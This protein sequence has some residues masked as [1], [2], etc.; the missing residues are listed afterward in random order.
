MALKKDSFRREYW[1]RLPFPFELRVYIFNVTNPD[2]IAK[3]GKPI[4]N[5]VGPFIYDILHEKIN[6]ED[7]EENDTVSYTVNNT[8]YF[9]IEKSNNLSDNMELTLVD[10]LTFGTANAIMKSSPALISLAAKAVDI[11]GNNPQNLFEKQTAK[12]LLFDGH[13]YSCEG[14]TEPIGLACCNDIKVSY[15]KYRILRRSE[16]VFAF[17]IFGAVNETDI[18]HGKTCIRRGIRNIMEVGDVVKHNGL[19]NISVWKDDECDQFRGTDGIAFHPFLNKK[20][21]KYLYV[22]STFYCRNFVYKYE[23]DI[24]FNGLKLLR[25]TTSVGTDTATN[26][27][28]KCYCITPDRCLKDGVFEIWKCFTNAFILSNPHFYLADKSYVDGVE[29]VNPNK[30]AHMIILD[31]DPLT[32]LVIRSHFRIQYSLILMNLEKYRLM[33]EVRDAFFPLMWA[34]E[35]MILPDFIVKRIKQIHAMVTV[36]QVVSYVMMSIGLTI[37][38]YILYRAYKSRRE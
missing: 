6:Q 9:N 36:A 31:I 21:N 20:K 8:Y 3:G 27:K 25:Y 23:S 15:Q 5:E 24:E 28:D 35:V 19:K 18:Y 13:S 14:V 29:G 32:G 2:D 37:C 4:L 34:D 38:G 11:I 17:S 16:N 1:S 30:D 7:D 22:T 10:L 33:K 12:T 26:E